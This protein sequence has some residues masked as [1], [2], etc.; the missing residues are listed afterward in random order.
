MTTEQLHARYPRLFDR[1]EDPD[2]LLRHLVVVDENEK[3]VT[4]DD[5]MDEL[6][7]PDTYSHVAYIYPVV[8]RAAGDAF[9][10][11]PSRLVEQHEAIRECFASEPD[12]WGLVTTLDNEAIALAILD[13][14]E[15][16]IDERQGAE[17][18]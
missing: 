7:D 6:Y 11:I 4:D 15:Q 17:D 3:D 9:E 5:I 16:A 8:V 13:A 14:V 1:L 18:A 12:Q 2:L 10:T